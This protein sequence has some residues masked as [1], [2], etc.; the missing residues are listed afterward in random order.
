MT[1]KSEGNDSLEQSEHPPHRVR[2][3]RFITD[4]EIGLGDA[5]K[6]GDIL[7]W[8]T[9]LRRLQTPCGCTQPLDGF[10]PVT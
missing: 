10:H 9:T 3:P 4:E 8:D 1:K 2:L 5:I 6:R 7:F